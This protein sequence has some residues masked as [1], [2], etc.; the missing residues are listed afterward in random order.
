M[1]YL[2]KP[3]LPLAAEDVCLLPLTTNRPIFFSDLHETTEDILLLTSEINSR[4]PELYKHLDE[5]PVEFSQSFKGDI[6]VSELKNYRDTINKHLCHH[7]NTRDLNLKDW[8][9]KF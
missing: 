9:I 5:T 6:T 1:E 8:N 7:F 3:E 2:I 4:Y